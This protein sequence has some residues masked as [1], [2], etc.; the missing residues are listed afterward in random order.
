M[1]V[2]PLKSKVRKGLAEDQRMYLLNGW[3]VFSAYPFRDEQERRAL[4]IENRAEL[5][6]NVNLPV[7]QRDSFR[8][9]DA[10]RYRPQAYYDFEVSAKPKLLNEAKVLRVT[11]EGH[12]LFDIHPLYEDE[13]DFLNRIGIV[14]ARDREIFNEIQLQKQPPAPMRKEAK[15]NGDQQPDFQN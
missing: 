1:G 9:L 11:P 15:R 14:N 13:W 7:S 3:S 6:E 5:M 10:G 12:K 2:K 8:D 4:W